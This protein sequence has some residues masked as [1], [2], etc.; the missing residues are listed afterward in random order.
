MNFF[1][2]HWLFN[3]LS[4][5]C[6]GSYQGRFCLQGHLQQSAADS[7][8][9]IQGK[10]SEKTSLYTEILTHLKYVLFLHVWRMNS[11]LNASD[12]STAE[13]ALWHKY[14]LVF[15]SCAVHVSRLEMYY[16]AQE[17]CSPGCPPGPVLKVGFI[18]VTFQSSGPKEVPNGRLHSVKSNSGFPFLI[19]V[20]YH[21]TLTLA[22][23]NISLCLFETKSH[24]QLLWLQTYLLHFPPYENFFLFFPPW[25][26][27]QN[28]L[29]VSV[30]C[31]ISSWPCRAPSNIFLQTF[32]VKY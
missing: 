28:G 1:L 26:A 9:D 20:R 14:T 11:L 22:A 10:L 21:L 27:L 32:L 4:R 31:L 7:F 17:P 12:L 16:G 13:F 24:P 23:C 6:W 5:L 2:I 18:N 29:I 25:Q 15:W 19:S 30:F 8:R 3:V